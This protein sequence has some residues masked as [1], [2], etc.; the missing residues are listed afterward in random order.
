MFVFSE[1]LT[2]IGRGCS[3]SSEMLGF[4]KLCR[5]QSVEITADPVLAA[6]VAG[7]KAYSDSLLV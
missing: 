5:S 7:V 2:F 3:R 4:D 6:E 1:V